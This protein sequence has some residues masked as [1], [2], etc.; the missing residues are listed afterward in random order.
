MTDASDDILIRLSR[1][2]AES[3]RQRDLV[4]IQDII[5]RYS[6]A[7]DWLDAGMLEGVFF[8]DAEIDYGFFRGSGQDFKPRLMEIERSMARRWHFT[9]QVKIDLQGDVADAA[10]YNLSLASV[11]ATPTSDTEVMLFCG[12]YLDRFA[13]RNGQ[14]GIARRKHLQV[15]ATVLKEIAMSGDF[16][17]LNQIGLA[18]PQH[19]DYLPLTRG[20]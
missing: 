15:T 9:A 11:A 20:Q 2:E 14:W 17:V 13:R 3:Q 16:A 19:A 8:D 4:A 12:Y 1:V 10:S 5:C 7:L 18:T 6:R